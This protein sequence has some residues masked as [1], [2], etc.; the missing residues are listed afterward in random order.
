MPRLT[1]AKPRSAKNCPLCASKI[2]VDYKDV[3]LLRRY[4]SERG[5]ILGRVRT[6]VCAK[7]QRQVTRAIL[8]ARQMALLP[9]SQT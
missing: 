5:K 8:R 6:G 1:T 9:F 7:H 3:V 2:E 4:I